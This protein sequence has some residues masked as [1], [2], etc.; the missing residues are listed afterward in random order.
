MTRFPRNEPEIAALAL[1]VTQ[2]FV[3]ATADFPAP[4]E[5]VADLRVK[6]HAVHAAAATRAWGSW[7]GG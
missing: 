6:L 3:Q 5:P 7:S 2:G 1:V 4:P